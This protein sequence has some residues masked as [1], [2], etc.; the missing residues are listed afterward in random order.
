[1]PPALAGG[2][3]ITKPQGR[4]KLGLKV[5]KK[6]PRR[7]KEY[8]KLEKRMKKKI[9]INRSNCSLTKADTRPQK[10]SLFVSKNSQSCYQI[11]GTLL[12]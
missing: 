10:S 2:F 9:E 5:N 6:P 1:M 8:N 12:F 11:D 3:S 7:W 4:P